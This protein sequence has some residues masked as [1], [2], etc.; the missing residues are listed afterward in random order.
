MTPPPFKGTVREDPHL[1]SPTTTPLQGRER[2][3]QGT[4]DTPL[5]CLLSEQLWT[6]PPSCR[7]SSPAA[8]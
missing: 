8:L 3:I 7:A 6:L 4:S 2:A 5:S 1:T